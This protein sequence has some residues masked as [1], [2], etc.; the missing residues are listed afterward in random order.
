MDKPTRRPLITP[1]F[2]DSPGENIELKPDDAPAWLVPMVEKM[3]SGHIGEQIQAELKAAGSIDRQRQAAVLMVLS[4]TGDTEELPEDAEVLLIHRS[5]TLR[6]HSGQIAFPG[7]RVDPE[8]ES[9]VDCAMREAWEETGLDRHSV[10]PLAELPEVHIRATGYPVHPILAYWHDKQPVQAIDPAETDEVFSV[11]IR[12]LLDPNVRFR[13]HIEGMWQ[14]PAFDLD[15]YVIWGFTAGLLN[16]LFEHAGWE[17][18]WDTTKLVPLDEAIE[19]SRNGH[20]NG[21]WD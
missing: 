16:A 8:D 7:G 5:P 15:G 4:G 1:D 18:P 2:P 11:P 13:V 6:S 20:Y 17:I 19:K 10:T 12:K 3:H 14:G 21:A 9:V